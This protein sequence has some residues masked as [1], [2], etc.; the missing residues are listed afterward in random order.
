[1]ELDINCQWIGP[2]GDNAEDHTLCRLE[3]RADEHILTK[4]VIEDSQDVENSAIV[5]AWPLA[6]WLAGNWWRILHETGQRQS[7][8]GQSTTDWERSHY[9]PAADYGYQ[10][11][12]IHLVSDDK[13]VHLH[14][15]P[16]LRM[17]F[18]L[19]VISEN[20]GIFLSHV[21]NSRKQRPNF[22]CKRTRA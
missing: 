15:T 5:S 3:I 13:F 11:P 21:K 16:I 4:N 8:Y 22:C 20:F 7:H 12:R 9:L 17:I 10:W 1:M 14:M 6:A 19:R 18:G 2:E